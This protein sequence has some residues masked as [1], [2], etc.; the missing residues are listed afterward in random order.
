MDKIT[1]IKSVD[2]KIK[3]LGHGVVNWNGS[4]QLE[5]WKSGASKPTKISNHNMPKLRGYTNIK[6]Y[7]DDGSPKSYH[8]PM[9]VDFSKVKLYISQNC[10][11]HHLFRGE[12]YN[13]QSPKLL[14]NP[15]KLLC[16]TVGLMRG[17][18]I[19]KNENKR[20]SPLL[21]TDFVDQLG[22]GNYEQM[23][24]SGSKEKKENKDGKE[25]SNS[26]FSKTTFGDTEYIAYGSISIEQLQFIPLCADFGRQSMIINNHEEGKEVGKK[27]T[28]Y[29][30]KLSGNDNALVKW[31]S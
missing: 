14:D 6:E 2:F 15:I 30:K 22:N 11:R 8:H 5:L 9:S 12:P 4:P 7:W 26:I 19:P 13:L 20:T 18:V 23:G 25:S 29:L 10:I 17:Y 27:I 16:S 28:D 31:H 1:G 3:A 24:Q 21:L